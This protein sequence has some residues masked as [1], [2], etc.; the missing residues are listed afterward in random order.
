M[1][2]MDRFGSYVILEALGSDAAGTCY[3]AAVPAGTRVQQLVHLRTLDPAIA[4]DPSVSGRLKKT[5]LIGSQFDYPN[6]LRPEQTAVQD[7]E[8]YLVRDF[9]GGTSLYE[10]LARC[11]KEMYP[12]GVDH[13]LFI[14]SSI[15]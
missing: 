13:A 9:F 10:L 12:L 11:K 6:L 2:R 14:L 15:L 3:R 7:G 1:E 5:V 8:L 4:A